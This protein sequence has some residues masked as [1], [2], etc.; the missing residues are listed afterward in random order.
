[1]KNRLS[2]SI[3]VFL[4]ALTSITMATYAWFTMTDNTFVNTMNLEITTGYSLV[5]DVK[6][7]DLYEQYYKIID[8][9]EL[10]TISKNKM[11]TPVT[12]NDGVN[13]LDEDNNQVSDTINSYIDVSLHFRANKAMNVHLSSE[14]IN[15]GDNITMVSGDNGIEKALRIS[16]TADNKTKI[17]EPV[18]NSNNTFSLEEN[19]KFKE[20]NCLF[21]LEEDKDKEVVM[22]IWLEGND[23]DCTDKLRNSLYSVKLNFVGSDQDYIPFNK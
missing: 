5:I 15:H 6:E 21:E 17:Y 14:D 19:M 11:L 1:M 12:T 9:E 23:S 16:F 18:G 10:K 7:N 8:G 22:R 2:Q 3:L 20:E 13:F 4:L